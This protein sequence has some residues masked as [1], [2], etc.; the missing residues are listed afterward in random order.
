MKSLA[1]LYRSTYL[2]YSSGTGSM[3][4][5]GIRALAGAPGTVSVIGSRGISA[6]YIYIYY[7]LVYNYS[8][9]NSYY[10]YYNNY[11]YYTGHN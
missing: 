2:D 6:I 7:L 9:A 4:T 8:I 11:S 3:G 1:G 5:T 10:I